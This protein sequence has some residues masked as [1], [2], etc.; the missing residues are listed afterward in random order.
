MT[1][2]ETFER[3]LEIFHTEAES[4]T[5]FLYAY[6]AIHATAADNRAVFDLLNTAALF[7][8]T[9][10]GALQTATFIVLGRMFD[11]N[12][13]HNIDRLLGFAQKNAAIFS[14]AALGIRKQGQSATP[15]D[16]L[17]DYLA[18]SYVP[19][20]SDFRRLRILVK[21][22][23]KVYE[24]RYRDIRHQWFAHKEIADPA[25]IGALFAK[26]NTR[27]LQ[28]L[29]TFLGSLY[30]A[31]WELFVNGRKPV[32]RPR[33]YSVKEMR[34]RPTPERMAKKVQER[35]TEETARFLQSAAT[36]ANI[37]AVPR[38]KTRRNRVP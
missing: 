9:N 14:K 21:K 15:P 4:A 24:A 27:E 2:A 28:R 8:N 10:L 5:Q 17:N 23:R 33:R 22:H 30:D 29:V 32:L 12:S 11:Q 37:T 35:I 3:E 38:M 18:T 7:W 6:L 31:L 13:K 20:P 36:P 26:T 19:K 16:W 25:A 34:T 1:P